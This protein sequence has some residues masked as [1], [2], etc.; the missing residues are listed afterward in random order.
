[1]LCWR[2]FLALI[3]VFCGA[4]SCSKTKM[5]SYSTYQGVPIGQSIAELQVHMGKPYE[6]KTLPDG[7]EEYIYIERIPLGENRTLFRRYIFV[8]EGD[9]IIEKKTTE[10]RTSAIHFY[11][12]FYNY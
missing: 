5:M 3:L 7:K 12:L 8:V 4:L 1:M 11:N 10:E 6:V 9:R 2:G